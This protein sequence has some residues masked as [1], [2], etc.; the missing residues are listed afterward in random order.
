MPDKPAAAF[1]ALFT[2]LHDAGLP[3]FVETATGVGDVAY[4]AGDAFDTVITMEADQALYEAAH[5]RLSGRKGILPLRGDGPAMLPNLLPRLAAPAVFWLSAPLPPGEAVP[6]ELAAILADPRGHVVCLPG[7]TAPDAAL[8]EALEAAP[9]R[10]AVA[11]DGVL[12]LVPRDKA[13]LRQA[14]SPGA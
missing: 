5:E 1:A 2:L 9:A 4:A 14:L 11:R 8:A 3:V 13:A 6:R 10:D 7:L 12:V